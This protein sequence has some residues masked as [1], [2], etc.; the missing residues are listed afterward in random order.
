MRL[1]GDRNSV[2]HGSTRVVVMS[3]LHRRSCKSPLRTYFKNIR[4]EFIILSQ[5]GMIKRGTK[6]GESG[7][8]IYATKRV[9][10]YDPSLLLKHPGQGTTPFLKSILSFSLS[11]VFKV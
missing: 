8:F 6:Y 2:R 11:L 4:N 7:W 3:A 9:I 10:S 5:R 1:I